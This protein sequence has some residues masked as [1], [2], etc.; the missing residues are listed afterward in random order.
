MTNTRLHGKNIYIKSIP[1]IK[2]C[3]FDTAKAE[4]GKII[5]YSDGEVTAELPFEDYRKDMRFIY[6]RKDG[7]VIY[8]IISAAVDDEQGIMFVND[9][10]NGILDGIHSLTRVGGNAYSYSTN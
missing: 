2:E 5:L 10:S 9:D 4:D 1:L 8:F 7:E 6:A 3:D